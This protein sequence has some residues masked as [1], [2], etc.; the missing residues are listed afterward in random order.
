MD[1]AKDVVPNRIM[2]WNLCNPCDESNVDRAAEIAA[3]APQVV[4]LQEA[5][6]RDVERIR[7]H[8]AN[9]HGLDY[10][11]EYGPVL[12]N[13]S[14]CGGAPWKPGGYGQALLSAAPMTDVVTA[15]YPDGGSEDRGYIAVTTEVAGRTVRVFNTHLAQRRQESVREKQTAVLAPQVARYG[16]AVVLGDF[17]AVPDAP[18]LAPMWALAEDT[19]AGCRPC[20]R[21]VLRADDGLAEQVRLRVPARAFGAGARGASEPV[22]RSP[23]GARR[24]HRTL[25]P[26]KVLLGGVIRGYTFR[27]PISKESVMGIIAWIFIGLISRRDRQGAHAGQGPGRHHRHHAHRHRGRPARRFPGQG[28]IR[29]GLDRRFLRSV[30]VDRGHHRLRH[31]PRAVPGFHRPQPPGRSR[32]RLRAHSVA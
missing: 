16:R 29:G 2:T 20:G 7:D 13:W 18:E 22:L 17:N 8:L 25:I 10:H 3:Y 27:E 14:R 1:A 6:V 11:V 23:S 5:C 26:L 12:R 21:R 24:H 30:D 31:S 4:G 28:D 32:P 9:L 19:D 15:E